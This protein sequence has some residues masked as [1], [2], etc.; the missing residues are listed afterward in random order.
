MREAISLSDAIQEISNVMDDGRE[1][2]AGAPC[3]ETRR[4]LLVR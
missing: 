3:I 1:I 4:Y 2:D